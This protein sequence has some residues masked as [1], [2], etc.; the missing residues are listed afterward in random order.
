MKKIKLFGLLLGLI[1]FFNIK[2]N[3]TD[4]LYSDI[5]AA[6]IDAGYTEISQPAG[7]STSLNFYGY[8]SIHF[9]QMYDGGGNAVGPLCVYFVWDNNS[10]SGYAD[11]ANGCDKTY[12]APD[13]NG[14]GE[15]C[16]APASTDCSIDDNCHITRCL[17]T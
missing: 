12:T 13:K 7:W 10:S 14:H 4:L 15:G 2:S 1:L 8:S 5:S 6:M 3:A 16:A 17:N 11:A 9:W